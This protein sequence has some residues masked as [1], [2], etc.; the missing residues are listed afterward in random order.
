MNL[1]LF[2]LSGGSSPM[3]QTIEIYDRTLSATGTFED[4]QIPQA[5]EHLILMGVLRTNLAAFATQECRMFFNSDLTIA[6]YSSE[7]TLASTSSITVSRTDN[8]RFLRAYASGAPVAESFALVM[9][10]VPFY[11]MPGIR[12]YAY[13]Q[14]TTVST[15]VSNELLTYGMEWENTMA[16]HKIT[17]RTDSH[18]LELF[19]AGSRLQIFGQRTA[20]MAT[21]GV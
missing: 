14:V 5:F 9:A 18:P 17:L 1:G 6:N 3:L 21:T 10:T 13:G 4:I 11:R 15:S 7:R 19:T 20:M 8:P 2:P 16:I 12:R